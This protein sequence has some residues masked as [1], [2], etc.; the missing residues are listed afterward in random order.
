MIRAAVAGAAGKMG[1][2]ILSALRAEK[3]FAV[4]GAFER[5][6]SDQVGRTIEGVTV[7]AGI[8]QALKAGADVVV[9]FTAPAASVQHARACAER[10]VAL[11]VGTTGL[12]PEEKAELGAAARRIPILFAPNMSVGVNVLFRLVGEAARALGSAYEVEIVEMHH[13]MKRDAPSGTALRLAEV[14]AG[15]LGLDARGASVYQRQGDTGARRAGT[16]G[17]QALRGG[18]VVGDHTVYFLADGERLELTHRATSRDNFARGAVRAARF[19]AGRA[20]GLYDMQDVLGFR[21]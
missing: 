8:E 2:R 14:A 21:T 16:I 6:D 18:D 7:S 13:R 10:G 11:V 3:D 1:S 17:V 15:A 5:P 12:S 4:T 19:I 20:P 9:D